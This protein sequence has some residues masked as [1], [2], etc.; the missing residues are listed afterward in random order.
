MPAGIGQTEWN[1]V[2][3]PPLKVMIVTDAWTPQV[4]GVVRTLEM[5]GRELTALGHEVRYVTPEGRTTVPLPTYSEIRLSLFA[6]G[7][8]EEEIREFAPDAIHIATEGTLGIGARK[9]CLQYDIPFTTSFH[10]RFPEYVTARFPFIR[11]ESVYRFLRW[12]HGPA[13]TMMVATPALQREL[14]CH[15]FKNLKIW[16]RGVDTDQFCPRPGYHLPYPGPVWLYVGRIAV[17]KNIEAFLKLDLPGTKVLIGDGPARASLAKTYPEAKFLG[18]R[19]G[20]ALVEA[21]AGS[22]V[23]VFPSKT[24]TFGLVVLEALACGTPVAAYP[25]QGPTDVIGDAPVGVLDEDLAKAC[26][27]A[28]KISRDDARAFALQRSWRSCTE[29]FLS[30]IAIDHEP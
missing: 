30:N 25:V 24:D 11:E 13:V 28:L 21:Y 4:N 9:T 16:S 5:L 7:T 29:Q 17:E 12:F 26:R 22:D 20:E 6:Q 23:F 8:L 3:H 19:T 1:A 2:V 10:T 14:E 18:P 15:G 27:E